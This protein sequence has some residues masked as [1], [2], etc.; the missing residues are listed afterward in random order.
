MKPILSRTLIALF[1]FACPTV[2]LDISAQEEVE[3]DPYEWVTETYSF[4]VSALVHG[5]ATEERGAL[6]APTIPEGNLTEEETLAFLRKS[7]SVVSHYLKEQGLA[8][9]EGSV[10]VFDPVSLSLAARAP[11]ITQS[12]INFTSGSFRQGTE[13]FIELN[14]VLLEGEA[15]TIRAQLPKAGE[16]ADHAEIL[17]QLEKSVQGGNVSIIQ[18]RR[19]EVRS[20][21]RSKITDSREHYVADN[22]TLAPN[23]T[24]LYGSEVREEGTTWE[25]DPVLGADNDTIDLSMA[26]SH[27][28]APSERRQISFSTNEKG[29]ISSAFTE[30]S[31]AKVASQFTLANATT[32][33]IGVW[34]PQPILSAGGEADRL[35]AAFVSVD[36]VEVLPL[37]NPK[38]AGILEKHADAIAKVPKGKP[39]FKKIADEIPEGMIV[40]RFRIPPTFL[41]MSGSGSGSSADPFADPISNEPTFTVRA[42]AKDILAS[43]GIP[44]PAGSSANYLTMNSTLVVRNTPENISLVEAYVMSIVSGVEKA[45]G[46]TAYIVEGPAEKIRAAVNKTR[47]LPNHI[48]AWSALSNDEEI[49]HLSSH[50]LEGRSG[51]RSKIEATKEYC[52]PVGNTIVTEEAK[53]ARKESPIGALS[54]VFET[55]DIGTIIEIDAVLGADE[56][57]VDMSY[58]INCSYALPVTTAEPARENGAILL[59]GPTTKFH[60]TSLSASITTR[61]GMMRLAGFWK[62]EGDP[63]FEQAN[64]LQAVF[65]KVDVIPLREEED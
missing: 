59:E 58:A 14:T 3:L 23:G 53:E 2:A 18:R 21:Q 42:T 41:S 33:M 55:M 9:P 20:G 60:N 52:F 1:I 10:V 38:L 30:S 51:Q 4:P 31:V 11:R 40:R 35:Q 16:T 65:L 12:S 36:I 46:V 47:G 48:D 50:W 61:D 28:F 56:H 17:T 32:K 63:R 13:S 57:T 8:L 29:A 49:A 26:L 22:L 62:P 25:F 54:G 45:I 43:A 39:V 7:N 44:F 19:T 34:K 64:L 6:R 15:K 24:L 27:H 37:L 5:F